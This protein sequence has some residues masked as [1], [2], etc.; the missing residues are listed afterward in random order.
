MQAEPGFGLFVPGRLYAYKRL[1][2]RNCIQP[3]LAN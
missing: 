3:N 2:P 1:R